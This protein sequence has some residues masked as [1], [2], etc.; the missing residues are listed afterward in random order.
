MESLLR[1][2]AR[3]PV[4]VLYLITFGLSFGESALFLD[5]LVPGEVGMVFMGAA[6][7]ERG[8]LLVGGILACTAGA[9]AGDSTGY[10]IGRRF[11]LAAVHRFRWTRRN[12]EPKIERSERYFERHGG[13]AVV[14]GRFVGA[15]RAVVPLIA[16]TSRMPYGRFLLWDVPAA[17]VSATAIVSIGWFV[18]P[19]AARA[20]DRF[21]LAITALVVVVG[22][23]YVVGACGDPAESGTSAR[24]ALP[25]S[26]PGT[27]ARPERRGYS[28][29]GPVSA[30]STGGG[31]KP[32]TPRKLSVTSLVSGSTSA[33]TTTISPA[34]NSL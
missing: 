15:L 32:S 25:D 12:L 17:L 19:S 8:G 27:H 6:L 21:S 9:V 30:N 18:G 34:R 22:A 31:S 10:W 20:V 5:L 7:H 2:A 24:A 23:V 33:S 14:A 16:G 3:L 11:G 29:A 1:N 4:G 28:P 13:R 26:R